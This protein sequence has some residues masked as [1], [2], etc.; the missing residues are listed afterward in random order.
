MIPFNAL[1]SDAAGEPL[2][3]IHQG[4]TSR[5]Q[6]D[7]VELLQM[8]QALEHLRFKSV[9]VLW[10]LSERALEFQMLAVCGRSH[11]VPAQATTLGKRL[12]NFCQEH[13]FAVRMLDQLIEGFPL[14]GI[15]GP[16]GTQQDM[17]DLLGTA[18]AQELDRLI[19]DRL[20]FPEVL[21]SVGQVYFR[22]LDFATLSVLYLLSSAPNNFANMVRLMAGHG[23]LHEGFGKEQKGSSAMPHKVNSRTC[24]RIR[25]LR[26]VL[27]GH[28]AM[29][30]HLVGDQWLEGDVSC[31]ATRRVALQDACLALDGLYE[32]LLTVLREMEVFPEAMAAEL[33]AYTPFL[34]TTA[35]LMAAV[36]E[37]KGRE[38]MHGLIKKHALA[39][40]ADMRSGKGNTLVQRLAEDPEY[41]LERADIEALLRTDYGLAATHVDLVRA[42]VEAAAGGFP[43]AKSYVPAPIR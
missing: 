5:D 23:L 12:A 4:L 24:E 10:Q 22:S 34:S 35:F 2:E 17:V 14:C 16:T 39:A 26:N 6:T 38:T 11:N 13:L 21:D 42:K 41:P 30:T 31:S 27:A 32:C 15:K 9:A 25:S 19:A 37:H 1:A 20:G 3:L 43:E 28:L 7:N 36:K 40:L 18:G 33:A 8:R 29:T